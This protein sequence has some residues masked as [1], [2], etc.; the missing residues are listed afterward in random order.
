MPRT[1]DM[2]DFVRYRNRDRGAGM[3]HDEK[4]LLG[5]GTDAGGK[6]AAGGILDD[7]A[8]DIRPLLV[9]EATDVL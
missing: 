5:L 1:Q 6:A 3:M 7:Q 9:A 2:A 8:D 4:G